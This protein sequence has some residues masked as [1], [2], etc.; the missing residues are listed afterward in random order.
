MLEK[1]FRGPLLIVTTSVVLGAGALSLLCGE[2]SAW[3]TT[4]TTVGRVSGPVGAIFGRIVAR[5]FWDEKISNVVGI[6]SGLLCGLTI[7]VLIGRCTEEW[8]E[9]SLS[10]RPTHAQ[11][12]AG[13]IGGLLS[14]LLIGVAAGFLSVRDGQNR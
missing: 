5:N 8:L 12:L 14:G 1:L 10:F 2:V 13:V 3:T 6:G 11:N 4:V 7:G 9:H